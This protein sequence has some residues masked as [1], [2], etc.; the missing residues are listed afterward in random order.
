MINV[1]LILLALT[2][3]LFSA[4]NLYKLDKSQKALL[5]AFD[6]PFPHTA[7]SASLSQMCEI[8]IYLFIT[9]TFVKTEMSG[10]ERGFISTLVGGWVAVIV[11]KAKYIGAKDPIA[12]AVFFQERMKSA[13]DG[14]LLTI[15][16]MRVVEDFERFK[17]AHHIAHHLAALHPVLAYVRNTNM[18][19]ADFVRL[20]QET[21]KLIDLFFT[22]ANNLKETKPFW[23]GEPECVVFETL[24]NITESLSQLPIPRNATGNHHFYTLVYISPE[25]LAS[26]RNS[27][28]IDLM[29]TNLLV[30]LAGFVS[31][32][33]A[34]K[35]LGFDRMLANT[36][37]RVVRSIE[38]DF[39][40]VP[41]R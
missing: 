35:R 30:I 23:A 21:E 11:I 2:G 36:Y 13:T 41:V 1:T 19:I 34:S 25:D 40:L 6:S 17:R 31:Y 33:E 9:M 10:L 24:I 27:A 39:G 26:K 14:L 8:V 3:F 5:K 7:S 28:E 32:A 4:Y 37:G 20:I 16:D 29:H 38:I 18:P 22:D 15:N 12:K